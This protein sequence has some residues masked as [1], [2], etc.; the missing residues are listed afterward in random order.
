MGKGQGLRFQGGMKV[1]EFK[2]SSSAASKS[3][4]IT[5]CPA[6]VSPRFV[7]YSQSPWALKS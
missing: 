3:C 4:H 5:L 1:P 7:H 6:P 2:Q